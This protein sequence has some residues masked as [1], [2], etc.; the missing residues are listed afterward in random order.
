MGG[1][2]SGGVEVGVGG[3]GGGGGD[4]SHGGIYICIFS[5][6]LHV[7]TLYGKYS[8][9]LTSFWFLGSY[10]AALLYL[11]VQVAGKEGGVGKE[12]EEEGLQVMARVGER[13]WMLI[14]MMRVCALMLQASFMLYRENTFYIERRHSKLLM[15]RVCALLLQ[16]PCT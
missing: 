1:G 13:A 16:V 11:R 7:E 2:G 14:M 9:A 4:L 6:V 3:G 12:E 15:M 8:R 10:M 5:K